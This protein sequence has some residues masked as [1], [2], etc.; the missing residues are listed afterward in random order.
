MFSILVSLSS[1]Y[2]LHIGIA[3]ILGPE[4]Y[5]IFGVLMSLY[6]IN[7]AVLNVGIPRSVSKFI[8]EEYHKA[9]LI[10][11]NSFWAQFLLAVIFSAVFLILTKHLAWLLRDESLVPFLV[12][13]GVMIVPFSVTS[14]LLSGCLN[15][16]GLFR[17][18]AAVKIM[19]PL[20]R[21]ALAFLFLALGFGL[22]GVLSAFFISL[23]LAGGASFYYLR[24]KTHELNESTAAAGNTTDYSTS[25]ILS[26]AFPLMLAVL[27]MAL[28]RNVNILF[29]KYFLQDYAAVA[30]YTAAFTL[31]NVSFLVFKALPLTLTPSISRAVAENNTKLVQKY[32]SSS[33]RYTLLLLLPL[34]ALV[35]ATA[36][37]LVPMLYPSSYAGAAPLLQVL[38]FS[39]TFLVLFSILI[40]VVTASGNPK[41]ELAFSVFFLLLLV[42]LNFFSIP[43][44]GLA[45]A[46]YAQA[47][48]A[49]LASVAA[50]RYVYK[51]F[52]VLIPVL[53]AV[54]IG[55][56]TL[57]IFFLAGLWQYSGLLLFVNYIVLLLLYLLLLFLF[58]EFTKDD[59]SF[60]QKLLM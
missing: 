25:K 35:A 37:K 43:K 41:M 8:S 14:F 21:V 12:L 18:Q 3:R 22:F 32:I 19:F 58:G 53:S 54:K 34:S 29:I 50:G 30:L 9:R 2:V 36:D 39:S 46:V 1:N 31:S 60:L 55:G 42:S 59:W 5:G 6:L 48:T 28:L 45:G 40:S 56:A 49:L 24:R 11:R 7:D 27:S 13:L 57:A 16:L 15:G 33:L 17:E 38:I 26:F 23:I 44:Y 4:S 47:A 10:I 20:V 51:Q 52:K